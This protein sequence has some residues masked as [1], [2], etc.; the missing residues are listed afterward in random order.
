MYFSRF[1]TIIPDY[2]EPKK[3]L[4]FNTLTQSMVVLDKEIVEVLKRKKISSD[5]SIINN[6]CELGILV[7][8]HVDREGY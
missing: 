1:N 3:Y 4:C 6:L 5:K 8:D 2:P 7:E